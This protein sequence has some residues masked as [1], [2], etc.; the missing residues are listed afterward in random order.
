MHPDKVQ[1]ELGFD[2]YAQLWNVFP[3]LRNSI[4]GI[5]RAIS[6]NPISDALAD[7]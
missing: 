6:A 1:K 4:S 2:V 3:G 5:S 7:R